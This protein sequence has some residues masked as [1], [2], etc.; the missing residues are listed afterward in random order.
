MLIAI[1]FPLRLGRLRR[2]PSDFSCPAFVSRFLSLPPSSLLL[3]SATTQ[4]RAEH[5][6]DALV[7]NL[8]PKRTPM[9]SFSLG[10]ACAATPTP[11]P[12]A[13]LFNASTSTLVSCAYDIA[14]IAPAEKMRCGSRTRAAARRLQLAGPDPGSRNERSDDIR[15]SLG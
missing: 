9:L 2:Q 8:R 11:R 15:V 14:P 10:S 3:P 4:V 7:R 1:H 6:T 12:V 5:P 13:A